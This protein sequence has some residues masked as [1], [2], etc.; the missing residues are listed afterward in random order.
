MSIAEHT[1]WVLETWMTPQAVLD[2][3]IDFGPDRAQ[4]WTETSH[5]RIYAVN[6]VG[7]TWADVTEGVPI[8]WSRERYDWSTPGVVTL[9]QLD[10]NVT[11]PTG[12]TRYTLTD[13]GAGT[14]IRCDRSRVYRNSLDGLLAGI[15]MRLF[16]GRVLRW[17][18]ARGLARAAELRG[19]GQDRPAG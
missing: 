7:P 4:I 17:Q 10:S 14:R 8:S 13:D 6:E 19:A 2:A 5:P 12:R 15:V 1:T 18:F 11:L 16:G 3:L 9:T